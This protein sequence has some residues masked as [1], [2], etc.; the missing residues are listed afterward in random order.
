MQQYELPHGGSFSVYSIVPG[1]QGAG[2]PCLMSGSDVEW[3][4]MAFTILQNGIEHSG[5]SHWT[6]MFALMDLR[7][8]RYLYHWSDDVIEGHLVLTQDLFGR[9]DCGLLTNKRAVHFSHYSMTAGF[10]RRFVPDGASLPKDV[11]TAN[12]RPAVIL[13]WLDMWRSVCVDSQ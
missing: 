1:S 3:E 5:E 13:N 7:T 4:R 11:S 12:F 2:I 6:D 8:N 9:D 10:W